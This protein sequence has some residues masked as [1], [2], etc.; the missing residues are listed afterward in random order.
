L[1]VSEF[2]CMVIL[3]PKVGVNSEPTARFKG[4]TSASGRLK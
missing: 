3:L 2:E 4:I 1:E